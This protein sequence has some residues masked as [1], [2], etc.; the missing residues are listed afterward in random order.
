VTRRAT[1]TIVCF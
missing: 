1:I